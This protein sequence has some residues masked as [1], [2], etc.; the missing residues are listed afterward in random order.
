MYASKGPEPR[1][2][3]I[4]DAALAINECRAWA[5]APDSVWQT[6]LPPAWCLVF[7]ASMRAG[8]HP[9]RSIPER[10]KLSGP[11]VARQ[12]WRGCVKIDSL[13]RRASSGLAGRLLPA[14]MS[15]V[16]PSATIA[17]TARVARGA[18]IGPDVVIGEYA[19]IETDVVVGARCRIDSHA[20]VKRWTALGTDNQISTGAVLGSDPLDKAFQGDRSYLRIGSGNSIR[21]HFTISRGT[22]PE[23]ETVIGDG[24]FIMTSGHI[25]HNCRIGNETVIASAT[26]V[27][28]HVQ[29]EDRAFV[30]GGIGVQQHLRIG[31]LSM[32]GGMTRV[33]Q[34]VTPYL[35]HV[36]PTMAVHGLN[37]VGLRR[38][39]LGSIEISG[40]RRAYR[41]LFR[42]GMPLEEALTKVELEVE[43]P[44]ARH[45]VEFIRASKRGVCRRK[46]RG[47]EK[48]E[49]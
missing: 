37:L 16:H 34:D 41:I 10:D 3:I 39:G 33:N 18:R 48:E 7:L 49:D 30:S 46:G 25:A 1:V 26:L 45:M 14:R 2:R 42:S 9:N 15:S 32:V 13:A 20:V 23:S 47:K 11:R 38:A 35:T 12:P 43:G 8:A 17:T 24:N 6:A 36:G 21:E 44:H 31:E 4:A 27:A 22:E 28:G 5:G 40:I 29:I 19:I